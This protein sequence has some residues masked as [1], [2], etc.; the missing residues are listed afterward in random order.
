ML[1]GYKQ[2]A[3]LTEDQAEKSSPNNYKRLKAALKLKGFNP[4]EAAEKIGIG[5]EGLRKGINR[6]SLKYNYLVELSKLLGVDIESIR[7]GVYSVVEKSEG[8]DKNHDQGQGKVVR[9][10]N[11]DTMNLP[12]QWIPLIDLQNLSSSMS[13]SNLLESEKFP[14]APAQNNRSQF[15][16]IM[17]GDSMAGLIESGYRVE[18]RVVND[19]DDIEPTAIYVIITANHSRVRYLE[20]LPDGMIRLKC[21]NKAYPDLDIPKSKIQGLVHCTAAYPVRQ[22]P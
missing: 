14:L 13:I 15:A 11:S 8:V 17:Q 20:P 22:L 5:L 2:M 3:K 12:G 21:H 9:F 4:G 10:T 16:F 1:L 7:N 6:N 19:F 18:G